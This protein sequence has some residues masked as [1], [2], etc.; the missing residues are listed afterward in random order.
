M[1]HVVNPKKRG[2]PLP[3]GCTDLAIVLQWPKRR[4]FHPVRTFITLVLVEAHQASEVVIGP[5]PECGDTLIRY[6]IGNTW[7]QSAFP[8]HLRPSVIAELRRLARLPPARFPS[9]GAF[10][11]RLESTRLRWGV[12]MTGP[13]AECV[14]THVPS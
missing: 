6:K 8:S 1:N 5:A 9:E 14:L 13:H 2:V 3:R 7:R 4:G 10:S 11:L 12:R